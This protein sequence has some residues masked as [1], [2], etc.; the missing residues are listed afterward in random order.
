MQ[1]RKHNPRKTR[2]KLTVGKPSRE[3]GTGTGQIRPAGEGGS[4]QNAGGPEHRGGN[5]HEDRN[6]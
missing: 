3:R 2:S 5:A 6:P 4:R 1:Q